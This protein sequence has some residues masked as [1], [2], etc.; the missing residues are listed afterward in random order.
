MIER[1]L[2]L[3]KPDAVQRALVGEIIARFERA[4]L[5]I[6][7]MKMVWVN[8]QF[9]LKHYTEDL[10]K[11]RGEEV[12]KGMVKFL[13][14]GPVIALVLE[15]VEAVEIVRKIVGSTEPKAALPG[16]IR[17]D[18]AHICFSYADQKKMVVHNLIHASADKN[19]AKYEVPLWFDEKEMHSFKTVHDVHIF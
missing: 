5:K 8:E 6:V 2:V 15:G 1:T 17:G 18:Y 14:E 13:Q 16:T 7:G 19:D 12:R 10:A 4:G 9:A 11:R 3:L